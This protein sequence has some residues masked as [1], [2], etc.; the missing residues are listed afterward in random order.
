M[1][2]EADFDLGK[3]ANNPQATKDKLPLRNCESDPKAYIE[4]Y[5]KAKNV[6]QGDTP[7]NVDSAGRQRNS[8]AES[9]R[10]RYTAALMPA[11]EEKNSE[12]DP[13][14]QFDAEEKEYERT[15]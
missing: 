7:S 1:L 11:I 8:L 6:E 12:V 13:K 4:I 15:I 14:E 9:T 2:G 5:I 10:S 3:Y